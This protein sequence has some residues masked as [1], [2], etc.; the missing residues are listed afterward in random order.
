MVAAIY[1]ALSN[2]FDYPGG[3]GHKDNALGSVEPDGKDGRRAARIGID[4]LYNDGIGLV[5]GRAHLGLAL[6]LALLEQ[7]RVKGAIARGLPGLQL[8]EYRQPLLGRVLVKPHAREF[9]GW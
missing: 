6:H 2:R 3:H 9:T 5:A 7:T 8:L 1:L 4:E